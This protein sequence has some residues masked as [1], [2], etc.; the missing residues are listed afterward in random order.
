LLSAQQRKVADELRI[1]ARRQQLQEART[2][3]EGGVVLQVKVLENDAQIAEARNKLGQIE[4]DIADMQ[5]T[6]NDL[7]GLPLSTKTQLDPD[8]ICRS[9]RLSDP[10]NPDSDHQKYSLVAACK[11]W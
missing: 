5:D 11:V 2:L 8:Q 7:V 1:E 9:W 3:V 4:D 6:F 10:G